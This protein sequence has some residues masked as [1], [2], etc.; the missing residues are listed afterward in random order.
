MRV[1]ILGKY[2]P[3]QGGVSA[4]TYWSARSLADR[5]YEVDVVT[6]AT[7]APH[8]LRAFLDGDTEQWLPGTVGQGRVRVHGTGSLARNSYLPWSN[9]F[10]SKLF[11]RA[12][13]VIGRDGC[14]GIV[15]WYFE[16]Y[17]LVAVQAGQA[18]GLPVVVRHAGSDLGRLANH[19]DLRASY[20]WM[21]GQAKAVITGGPASEVRTRLEELAPA[22]TRFVHV[23]R[24]RLPHVFSPAA[25][26]L[27]I[28]ALLERLPA[29]FDAY[30]IAPPLIAEIHRVN[31]KSFD[32][33]VPTV[34]I[35]GKVGEVKGTYDL[36]AALDR[37][38]EKDVAFNFLA[39]ACG[40]A[41]RLTEFYERVMSLERLAS[42]TYLLP[43]LAPWLV[44]GFLK[45]CDLVCALERDFPIRF[46]MPVV[47]REVLAVATCLVVSK[48]LVEK[49]SVRESL[50]DLKNC[51]IIDD[52]RNRTTLAE[53]LELMLT[54]PVRAHVIGKHGFYLSQAL[55][56]SLEVRD[57]IADVVD[58][59]IRQW[60]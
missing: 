8:G 14:D 19:P 12:L 51:V 43:P 44:P 35:Y 36:L 28:T 26:P 47:P 18:T 59:L 10:G 38:A 33:A 60:V 31:G 50:V 23:G 56:E 40:T 9:P 46:H 48:E 5:G 2:P 58:R 11:G 54:D 29:W 55:E 13:E 30:P 21:L 7:E 4:Q 41:A 15:G 27:D 6:N 1:L 52:P 25:Q 32:R 42:H 53:R 45:A 57:A 16:P 39:L 24:S 20:R 34:G 17:G 22:G 49:Q 3:L 37:L